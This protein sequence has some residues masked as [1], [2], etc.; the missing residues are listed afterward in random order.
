MKKIKGVSKVFSLLLTMVM[1]NSLLWVPSAS[2][3]EGH[4]L[5]AHGCTSGSAL[6][7]QYSASTATVTDVYGFGGKGAED[8]SLK[9]ENTGTAE[10]SPYLTSNIGT[11]YF[12]MLTTDTSHLY[13][14]SF[15]VY[16]VNGLKDIRLATNAHQKI[17]SP[18]YAKDLTSG[19]WNRIV[20]VYDRT[21][22]EYGSQTLYVNGK[23]LY[24]PYI[25]TETDFNK[26]TNS[27]TDLENTNVC[28]RTIFDLSSGAEV[29]A[30]DMI[31]WQAPRATAYLGLPQL[32]D[33]VLFGSA[34][35]AGATPA[36]LQEVATGGSGNTITVNAYHGG[37]MSQEP[38]SQDEAVKAGDTIL[39]E[40]LVQSSDD[41]APDKI[42]MVY[43]YY[44]VAD[45]DKLLLYD[46]EKKP[47][48]EYNA[49]RLTGTKDV[50]G[51]Y[52]K[53]SEEKVL[54]FSRDA[55]AAPTNYTSFID[56]SRLKDE[57]QASGN[58]PIVFECDF[59]PEAHVEYVMFST[60]GSPQN[61]QL[62]PGDNPAHPESYSTSAHERTPGFL[63]GRWSKLKMVVDYKKGTA[64]TYV[65]GVNVGTT[66]TPSDKFKTQTRFIIQWDDADDATSEKK[67]CVDN[68]RVY[69]WRNPQPEAET[70]ALAGIADSYL[71][72]GETLSFFGGKITD[73][74]KTEMGVSDAWAFDGE[75]NYTSIDGTSTLS[76]DNLVV[77]RND[78]GSY[79]YYTVREHLLAVGGEG[80][81]NDTM[82]TDGGLHFTATG[83]GTIFLAHFDSKDNLLKVQVQPLTDSDRAVTLEPAEGMASVKA[84]LWDSAQNLVPY[85]KELELSYNPNYDKTHQELSV[86]MIGNSFSVDMSEYLRDIAAQNGEKVT[87]GILNKGGA[88]ALWHAQRIET[89]DPKGEGIGFTYNGTTSSFINLKTALSDYDWDVVIL[90]NWSGSAWSYDVT[91][92]AYNSE[93]KEPFTTL[94]NYVR[95]NEPDAKIMIQETWAYEQSYNNTNRAEMLAQNQRIYNQI[96]EDL[97]ET[98]GYKP[99]LI[100]SGDVFGAAIAYVKNGVQ[101]FN[102]TYDASKHQF[103]GGKDYSVGDGSSL[104]SNAD[105]AEGKITLHRD[106]F[107]AGHAGRYLL[108][109][110]AYATIFN[111]SVSG[112]PFCPGSMRYAVGAIDLTDGSA[113]FLNYD[114][115]SGE[116]VKTL[117]QIVDDFH[118]R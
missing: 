32:S 109:A 9:L 112:N 75:S 16:P 53:P 77:L 93:W 65:N 71:K 13:V 3:T 35:P 67:F 45:G 34:V 50:D 57:Y 36:Q 99:E 48:N 63:H 88:S 70:L 44:Q 103:A 8:L 90:Q 87:V 117:Q 19:Q 51:F 80:Y 110:N 85:T 21:Q 114:A 94:A 20:Y 84:M 115:L 6:T 105:A 11:K 111:K 56:S 31:V 15:N 33:D 96:A 18:V 40:E 118:N 49:I 54:R 4:V 73:D 92:A 66:L 7:Y 46:L 1:L 95:E 98:L 41:A 10:A 2:A 91:S 76:D 86:L 25:L 5:A 29:Y 58:Y 100:R 59:L 116:V 106:G 22:G 37:D 68:F 24:D 89:D 26:L 107:H 102:T 14:Y 30:D 83:G 52:G 28:Y 47:E 101:I 62:Y 108:A 38:L 104:L 27:A 74:V 113:A 55:S 23:Q 60:G 97:Q 69:E 64:A 39:L 17:A 78:A 61:T 42:R 81:V 12:K 43:N 79:G 72:Q 82:Y